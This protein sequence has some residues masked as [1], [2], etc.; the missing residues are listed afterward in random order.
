MKMTP[1]VESQRLTVSPPSSFSAQTKDIWPHPV[2]SHPPYFLAPQISLK[3][4]IFPST[5]PCF[6][7]FP[8]TRGSLVDSGGPYS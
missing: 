4:C 7:V 6:P 3:S 8:Q 2:Y 5:S 1:W